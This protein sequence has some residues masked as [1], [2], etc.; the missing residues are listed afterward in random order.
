MEEEDGDGVD[1]RGTL[2]ETCAFAYMTALAAMAFSMSLES[3][4][5]HAGTGPEDP[6]V[7]PRQAGWLLFSRG[8]GVSS[9]KDTWVLK[10]VSE[11]HCRISRGVLVAHGTSYSCRSPA[12]AGG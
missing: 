4:Q 7:L 10:S 11:L 8:F 12:F 3:R 6:W 5:Q 1:W 2:D 9:G